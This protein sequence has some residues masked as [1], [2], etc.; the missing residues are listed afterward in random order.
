MVVR[1]RDV[2]IQKYLTGHATLEEK[3]WLLDTMVKF[4]N[5]LL[6]WIETR[7]KEGVVFENEPQT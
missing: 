4:Y 2:I 1:N 6:A 5:D 3:E 7:K